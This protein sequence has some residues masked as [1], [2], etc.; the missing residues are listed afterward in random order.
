MMSPSRVLPGH[1]NGGQPWSWHRTGQMAQNGMLGP[2]EEDL[3]AGWPVP[4]N[5]AK[6]L[7]EV[8]GQRELVWS[9]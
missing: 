9:V 4:T 1:R 5:S 8:L 7:G 3:W 2:K 6:V